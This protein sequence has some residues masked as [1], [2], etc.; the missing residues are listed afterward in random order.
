MKN[1]RTIDLQQ[2]MALL[3]RNQ[4]ALMEAQFEAEKRFARREKEFERI[5]AEITEL[6]ERL[7][8]IRQKIG[9]KSR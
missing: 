7:Q 3:I 6:L 1:T 5:F 8:A 2:A 4:A 9:F